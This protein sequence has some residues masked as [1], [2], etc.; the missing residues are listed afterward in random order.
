M[1]E[2]IK[3]KKYLRLGKFDNAEFE[4]IIPGLFSDY[5]IINVEVDQNDFSFNYQKT[6]ENMMNFLKLNY[7]KRLFIR[8]KTNNF[9]D[10]YIETFKIYFNYIHNTKIRNNIISFL[11]GIRIKLSIF[12]SN[13]SILL[14]NLLVNIIIDCNRNL[15][16]IMSTLQNIFDIVLKRLFDNMVFLSVDEVPY[17]ITY[18]DLKDTLSNQIPVR[19]DNFL[20]NNEIAIGDGLDVNSIINDRLKDKA[21][22]NGQQIRKVKVIPKNTNMDVQTFNF[23]KYESDDDIYFILENEQ[24]K[25]YITVEDWYEYCVPQFMSRYLSDISF[26]ENSYIWN[27]NK[28][29]GLRMDDYNNINLS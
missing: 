28:Q 26:S 13:L 6:N 27:S 23:L 8:I 29:L 22:Q 24:L 20:K 4:D 21:K 17:K 15:K 2:Y 25:S 11:D 19:L 16:V 5:F 10:E 12:W 14:S 3:D 18:N 1:P 9:F 7:T